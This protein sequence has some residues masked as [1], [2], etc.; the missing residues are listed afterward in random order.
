A[1]ATGVGNGYIDCLD[2]PFVDKTVPYTNG[3]FEAV[4]F[5]LI[6]TLGAEGFSDVSQGLVSRDN[7]IFPDDEGQFGVSAKWYAEDLGGTEFSAF[8]QNYASRLPFASEN[9]R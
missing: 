9:A 2:S 3:Q 6:D 5:G 1:A 4:K 7:D 8:Y